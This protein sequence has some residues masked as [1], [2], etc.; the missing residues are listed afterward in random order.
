MAEF[1]DLKKKITDK[2]KEQNACSEQYR[3][4]LRSGSIEDLLSVVIRNM[5]WCVRNK[6]V[7]GDILIEFGIDLLQANG[8][9]VGYKG[10]VKTD[11]DVWV[12]KS[13]IDAI[14]ALPNSTINRVVSWENS[15][16]NE[17]V[18]RDNSTINRVVSRDNSTI[19]R[20]VSRDNSTINRVV[21]WE[22]STINEV[23][24]WENSTINEVVSRDN[25][26]INRVVSGDN[27]TINLSGNNIPKKIDVNGSGIVRDLTKRKIYI[28]KSR[29]EIVELLDNES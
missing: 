7:N 2:A 4:A 23:V 12:F 16:I 20:V 10:S 8:V 27:S 22:N 26:T 3:A 14:E 6:V 9:Y 11:K 13:K 24:S 18:S 29:F 25:S 21:S 15:T 28:Y 5:E 19:N 17:V 1:K